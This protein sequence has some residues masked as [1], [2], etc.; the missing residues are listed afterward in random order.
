MNAAFQEAVIELN[1]RFRQAGLDLH[2]HNGFIQVASDPMVAQEIEVP[3]WQLVADPKWTNVDH[4]CKEAVDL[5]DT[6]GR[7]PAFYA[8]RALEST[9]KIISAEKQLS[10]GNERGAH[11]YIDNLKR[12]KLIENWEAEALKAIFTNVR[13]PLGHGPGSGQMPSLNDH[14]TNWAIENCMGWV[15]SLVRRIG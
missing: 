10:T 4:D 7:D 8:A 3:F 12:G 5:R 14:Q 13:N 11:N 2:Y 6:N 1:A 9:I 15:K